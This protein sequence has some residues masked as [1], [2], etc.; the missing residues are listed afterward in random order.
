LVKPI[1]LPESYFREQLALMMSE[2]RITHL[3]N[4]LPALAPVKK[5]IEKVERALRRVKQAIKGLPPNARVA[6]SIYWN[7]FCGL[8][9]E[10]ICTVEHHHNGIVVGQ[11]GRILD[12]AKLQAAEVAREILS[13]WKDERPTKTINGTFYELTSVM[14][15]GGTGIVGADL[16]RFCRL[17]V[18]HSEGASAR[19]Y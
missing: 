17:V 16:T 15:E 12:S 10:V 6:Q 18:H 14:Y 8:I 19:L 9:E 2:V 7:D 1:N 13:R 5:Q 4:K 3:D 11:G